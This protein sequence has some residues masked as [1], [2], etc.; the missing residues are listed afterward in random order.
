M[1]KQVLNLPFPARLAMNSYAVISVVDKYGQPRAMRVKPG[2][3]KRIWFDPV[4]VRDGGGRAIQL[5]SI[6]LTPAREAEGCMFLKD[7]Y[8]AEK[9]PEGWEAWEKYL[10]AQYYDEERGAQR[11]R[12]AIRG[13]FPKGLLP[14]RVLAMQDNAAERLKPQWEPPKGLKHPDPKEAA[15]RLE[16]AELQRMEDEEAGRGEPDLKAAQ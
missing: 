15:K 4:W 5:T 14:K 6:D 10:R 7:A 11:P 1:A 16:E 2:S 8:L 9:W 3:E 13:H 12:P